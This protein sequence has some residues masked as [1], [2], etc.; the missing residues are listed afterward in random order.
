M[1]NCTS[2]FYQRWTERIVE[3]TTDREM[4]EYIS[5]NKEMISEHANKTFEFAERIY[6]GQIGDNV[7]RNYHIKDDI[8]FITNTTD[9]AFV[10]VYKVDLGFTEELNST[11]RKGLIEEIHRL[12]E[13]KDDIEIHMLEEIESKEFEI[14]STEEQIKIL[15]EQMDN[16]KKSKTFKEEEVKQ[17]KKE[18]LNV[19]LELKKYALMLVNSKE[20]KNDLLSMKW[21]TNANINGIMCI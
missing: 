7:T 15:Q 9:D 13:E 21:L 19:G 20:Y 3:I 8:V 18:S 14:I 12:S 6:T 4:K 5:K 10:T 17:M 2:H 11:V 16:L 1:K